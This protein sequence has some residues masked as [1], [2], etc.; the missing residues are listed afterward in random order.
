M[1]I[2]WGKITHL[3]FAHQKH[4]GNYIALRVN[5]V[6]FLHIY[7]ELSSNSASV[8]GKKKRLSGSQLR[9]LCFASCDCGKADCVCLS[10]SKIMSQ[11]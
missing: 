4:S 9:E 3:S 6:T 7:I 1:F 5:V 11:Y 10:G 8:A 2:R